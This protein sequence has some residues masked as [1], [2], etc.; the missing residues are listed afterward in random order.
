MAFQKILNIII[1]NFIKAS[2]MAQIYYV[3]SD[4]TDVIFSKAW[5]VIRFVMLSLCFTFRIFEVPSPALNSSFRPDAWVTRP[6]KADS[7]EL[8]LSQHYLDSPLP[9]ELL[10]RKALLT[11][12]FG[13]P[14]PVSWQP[15]LTSL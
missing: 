5:E 14:E 7:P 6:K 3:I 13:G 8:W 15:C 4:R 10:S 2:P 12:R 11:A 9:P 1:I